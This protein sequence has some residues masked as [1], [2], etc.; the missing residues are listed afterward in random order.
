MMR[1]DDDPSPFVEWGKPVTLDMLKVAVRNMISAELVT[2]P[3]GNVGSF[4]RDSITI[5]AH[6]ADHMAGHLAIELRAFVLAEKKDV[7]TEV[8]RLLVLEIEVPAS[9]W[10]MFRHNHRGAWWMRWLRRPI[11]YATHRKSGE[12]H[13]S[14]T[15]YLTYPHADV[16]FRGMGSPV[17]MWS[18]S[19]DLREQP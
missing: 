11:R 3:N 16:P 2:R 1:W 15:R 13:A 18:V 10:H 4:V 6:A 7:H 14:L 19:S 5:D 12:L 9:P 17:Q 8:S